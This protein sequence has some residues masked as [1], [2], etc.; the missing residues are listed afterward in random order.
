MTA[1]TKAR[2]VGVTRE[3]DTHFIVAVKEAPEKGK[4]NLAI[5]KA[6]ADFLGIAQSRIAL[7]SGHTIKKKVFSIID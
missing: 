2:K 3:G 1:K 7:V 6:L 4:A 5:I